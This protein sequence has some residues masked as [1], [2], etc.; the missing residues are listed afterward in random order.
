VKIPRAI[1]VTALIWWH[2]ACA[3]LRMHMLEKKKGKV[4]C[5]CLHLCIIASQNKM[6][7]VT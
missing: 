6:F 4:D 2:F 3:S 7:N 5:C 1:V